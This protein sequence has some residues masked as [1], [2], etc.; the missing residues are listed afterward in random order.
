M[1]R[2]ETQERFYQDL[3]APHGIT[4]GEIWSVYNKDGL[5]GGVH[6]NLIASTGHNTEASE[7][8][9]A[10]AHLIAAAPC[11]Y[12]ALAKI[13]TILPIIG[14]ITIRDVINNYEAC[15][16]LGLNQWCINEGRATGDEPIGIDS[17]INEVNATLAKARGEA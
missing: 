9:K 8:I 12:E 7:E 15:D 1:Q 17:I 14:T 3:S 10:N 16:A 4:V 6:G 11:L 5:G 2:D 13:T